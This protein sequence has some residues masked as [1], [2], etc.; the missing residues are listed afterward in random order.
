MVINSSLTNKDFYNTFSKLLLLF[1]LTRFVIFILGIFPDSDLL[2]QMWQILN[3]ELL[4]NNLFKSLYYL[5]YQ[6]PMWNFFIGLFVKTVGPNYKLIALCIYLFNLFCSLLNIF[7][8]LKICNF[9]SLSKIKTYACFFIFIIFSASYIFYEN[10]GHYTHFTMTIYLF[11]IVNFLLF[12]KT[13]KFFYEFFIYLSALLLV[14]TWSAFSHPLFIILIFGTIILIKYKKNLKKSIFTFL[15]AI[16]ISSLLSFKNKIELNFFGNSSWIGL[17]VIQVLKKWEVKNGMCNMEINTNAL[18]YQKKYIENNVNFVNN[19]PTLI[20]PLSGWNNVG[21]IYRTKICLKEGINIVLKDPSSYFSIVKFNFISTHGHYSFDHGFK[22]AN[23]NKFFDFLDLPKKNEF[24]NFLKV[25]SLQLYYLIFY[26]F[27]ASYLLLSVFNI[28]KESLKIEKAVSSL[29]LIWLWMIVLTHMFAG[30]EHERMRHIG[31]FLHAIF[32]II[33]IKNNFNI[34][35][36]FS[37]LMT[38][39]RNVF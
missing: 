23:W 15:I 11:L 18:I 28:K 35:K 34:K 5:H 26:I 31:H 16:T 17:Q 9:F 21:M 27:F 6:P 33:L 19:D 8:F 10:Y 14:Y 1:L 32:F 24:T 7:I 2:S 22:P 25:R 30:F 39:N 38:P 36:I 12:A 37:K 29:F 3:L 13:E 4:E 20:G